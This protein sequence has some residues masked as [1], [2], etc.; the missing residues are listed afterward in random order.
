MIAKITGILA[1]VGD[2]SVLIERDGLCYEVLVPQYLVAELADKVGQPVVLHT[3]HY[4]EGNPG[5]GVMMPRLAGF[6]TAEQMRAFQ[7]IL[8]AKGLGVRRALRA[9]VVPIEQVAEAIERADAAFLAKL[10]GLGKRSAEQMIASLKGK[11]TGFAESVGRAAAAGGAAPS[12]RPAGSAESFT[13]AQ[14]D[15]VDVLVAWGERRADAER[16]VK[17]AAELWPDLSTPEEWI[18][19]AY[20]VKA[21]GL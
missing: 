14:R 8:T 11:F 21:G 15:A 3:L 4:L 2:G 17:R 12:T 9:L 1:E 5:A 20:R 19:A 13:P 6:A 7:Q 18:K 10:P 16:F